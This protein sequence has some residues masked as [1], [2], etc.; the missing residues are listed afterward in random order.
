MGILTP[1]GKKLSIWDRDSCIHMSD[2]YQKC[3]RQRFLP[4]LS[5]GDPASLFPRPKPCNF[6]TSLFGQKMK[7]SC[8]KGTK[9]FAGAFGTRKCP[10][11]PILF[12]TVISINSFEKKSI[13]FLTQYY[14]IVTSYSVLLANVLEKCSILKSAPSAVF[15]ITSCQRTLQLYRPIKLKQCN[16]IPLRKSQ[17]L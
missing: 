3:V 4:P 2:F 5:T 12:I 15:S 6:I 7:I 13:F 11:K 14:Q 10:Y 1:K 17:K 16:S 9:N 8:A